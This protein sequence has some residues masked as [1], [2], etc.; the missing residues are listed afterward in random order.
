[1]YAL[2][3]FFL[4]IE[5]KVIRSFIFISFFLLPVFACAQGSDSQIEN[6]QTSVNKKTPSTNATAA[7][8]MASLEAPVQAQKIRT[9]PMITGS[10]ELGFLYKT[11]NT[12]SGDMKT[13]LDI[14]FEKGSWLSLLNVDLLLKK[15]DIVDENGD[16]H[17][18]TT[19]QK[20]SLASQTN[21]SLDN[22]EKNYV[23]GNI[24]FEESEFSSFDNQS[25]ISMGWG[26]HWYKNNNASLWGDI[27]PGYK[28]DLFKATGAE[29][30]R[31]ADTWIVQA[32]ALYIRKLGEHIELKQL[33]SVKQ[34]L[35]SR[36]NNTYKAE[37]TVTT[38][39]ISTLQLKFTFTLDYNSEA[40]ADK[41][42][43][44]TQTAVTL[45]YSF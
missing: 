18:K 26:H 44:D 19:D 32:Q 27:G 31:T 43:L 8:I 25:S 45:V 7:D 3:I 1:M 20:W 2:E 11:G 13:G 15:S 14:R 5:S 36:E 38:K 30:Q 42:N 9:P 22:K 41:E 28:R 34:A 23:Y 33:F 40:E 6:K 21:Y 12:N 37:T 24:W 16:D 17:F 39:L 29:P 4:K 35:K 10:A